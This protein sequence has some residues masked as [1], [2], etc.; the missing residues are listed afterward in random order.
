MMPKFLSLA[1]KLPQKIKKGEVQMKKFLAL[2]AVIFVVAFAGA[3]F[4]A[5]GGHVPDNYKSIDITTEK[6][7]VPAGV[8]VDHVV[9]LSKAEATREIAKFTSSESATPVV[10]GGLLLD[11]S[12]DHTTPAGDITLNGTGLSNITKA[13]ISN[14]TSIDTYTV[15]EASARDGIITIKNVVFDK[16]FSAASVFVGSYQSTGGSGSSGG[17]NAGFAG[18][19]LFAAAPLLYF[20]KK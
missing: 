6:V 5:T 3:S 16:H 17:C 19:L 14:K 12:H 8:S 1:F 15:Y 2:F 4:A 20:R 13:W 10:V 7:G 18:L 9:P 11:L